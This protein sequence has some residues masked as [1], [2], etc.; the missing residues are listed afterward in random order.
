MREKKNGRPNRKRCVGKQK[1][2]TL[3]DLNNGFQKFYETYGHHPTAHE[4]DDFDFLPSSRS[5]QRRFGGLV[6]LRED[7]KLNSDSDLRKG[8]HSSERAT[9]ISKRAHEMGKEVY[10]YLVKL[11]GIEFVHREYF[12]TDDRRTRTDFFICCKK[13]NFSVDV[14]FPENRRNLTGCLNSKMK[15]YKNEM[16]IQ[17]PVIFLQMNKKIPPE[18]VQDILIKKKNKLH[19]Y[20]RL[21]AFE[22]FKAFCKNRA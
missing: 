7:L 17:Y 9:M 12:F 22:E 4:I 19:N 13:G 10:N 16:M 18:E 6:A 14:F 2:W 11:F 3:E 1:G 21:M 8:V 5:I 15:M 20:Q